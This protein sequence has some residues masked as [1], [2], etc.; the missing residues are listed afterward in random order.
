MKVARRDENKLARCRI[1]IR[2][3]DIA[4]ALHVITYIVG[5]ASSK[6]DGWG[7]IDL[8]RQNNVW[9]DITY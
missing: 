9:Q 5:E 1:P 8:L 7:D 4:N 2:G 3:Q 6:R